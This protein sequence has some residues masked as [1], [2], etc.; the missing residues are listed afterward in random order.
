MNELLLFGHEPRRSRCERFFVA[1]L[2]RIDVVV[3]VRLFFATQKP[4]REINKSFSL[5]RE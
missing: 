3:A 2:R 5:F 1:S 4:F